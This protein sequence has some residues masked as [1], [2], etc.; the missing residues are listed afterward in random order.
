MILSIYGDFGFNDV[1]VKLSTRPE[2][3]VGS[4]EAWDKAEA[5]LQKVLDELARRGLKTSVNRAK[6]PSMA[7]SSNIPCATRS[8]A[9]GNAARRR[10]TST[11][12]RALAPSTLAR[13]SE[14]KTPV[15]VHRAMFG[16]LER[17]TGILIE[18]YAGHLPLWLSPVQI[19]VCTITQEADD[20]ALEVASEARKRGLH[21][22]LTCATRRS[23]TRCANI[24]WPRFP[25]CWSRARRRRPSAVSIRRLGSQEQSAATLEEALA[26]LVE[27]ATPP[28]LKA[29]PG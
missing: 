23:P 28:D 8:A 21:V 16:S 4:D 9:N 13:D 19:V 3:R 29:A 5:A 27:E 10:S 12:R 22:E 18:H 20:Y 2:K 6:A 26:T 11:C 24:R 25:C 15:M 14:K 7:P 17:F 1:V